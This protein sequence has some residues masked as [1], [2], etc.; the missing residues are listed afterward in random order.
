M[1]NYYLKSS[2]VQSQTRNIE[3]LTY[4]FVEELSFSVVWVGSFDPLQFPVESFFGWKQTAI[5]CSSFA[6]FQFFCSVAFVLQVSVEF[7]VLCAF[8][9]LSLKC[10]AN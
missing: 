4:E 9:G 3:T 5:S 1:F 8:V 2:N 10:N 7:C 6:P